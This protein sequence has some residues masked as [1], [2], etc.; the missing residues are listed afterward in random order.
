MTL[1]EKIL[2][3]DVDAM[4]EFVTELIVNTEERLLHSVAAQ[5]VNVSLVSLAREI[6]V[7]ENKATLLQEVDDGNS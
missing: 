5:G 7:A 6:R 2:T 4:A 3:F 1:Y